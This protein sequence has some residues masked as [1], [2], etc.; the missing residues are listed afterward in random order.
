LLKPGSELKVGETNQVNLADGRSYSVYIPRNADS[1]A[2][3]IVAMHGAGAGDGK[4]VMEGESGLTI[5]AE[6]IGAIVVF[7]TPKVQKFDSKMGGVDGVAWS[8]PGR[9]DLSSQVDAH[10]NEIDDRVYLDNVLD[11]LA[12]KATTA[13]KV[14][15]FGFSDG[16]RFA[17]AYASDR[18]ERVAGVVSMHGTWME[19]DKPPADGIPIMIVHGD[20][21]NTLPYSGGLG[22]MSGKMD[23]L[24]GTNLANSRPDMQK[25]VWSKANQCSGETQVTD[26]ADLK[27]T[28]YENCTVPVTEYIVKGAN[29]AMHDYKNNGS[30]LIQWVLGQPD[31]K[32]NFSTGGARFLRDR[33]MRSPS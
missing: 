32:Q 16:A 22:S 12:S 4:G 33:I 5:D 21:D 26:T 14:G 6:R 9:T 8:V 17:Q 28:N 13:D 7:P 24:L 27:T 2:P 23:W 11:D 18:P 29:H 15:L 10:D 20:H 3:V 25:D 19:G 1:R 31:L 30:R